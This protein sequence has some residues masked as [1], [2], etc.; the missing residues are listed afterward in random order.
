MVCIWIEDRKLGFNEVNSADFDSNDTEP[1][2]IDFGENEPVE[3]LLAERL[4]D[5]YFGEFSTRD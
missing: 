4:F 3:N 5:N 2:D 1:A